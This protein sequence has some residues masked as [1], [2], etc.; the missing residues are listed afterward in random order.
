[1]AYQNANLALVWPLKW[2]LSGYLP[3]QLTEGDRH[4]SYFSTLFYRPLRYFEGVCC[5]LVPGL[6]VHV[7]LS[8]CVSGHVESRSQGE[9]VVGNVFT[10]L[11][12]LTM[13]A[14][15][16]TTQFC[17]TIPIQMGPRLPELV[18]VF[19]HNPQ[20]ATHIKKSFSSVLNHS[21]GI[22]SLVYKDSTS[23][24]LAFRATSSSHSQVGLLPLFSLQ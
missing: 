23:M 18:V 2:R 9:E 8:I 12:R 5:F 10:V 22:L 15:V 24:G 16:S 7:C 4:G 13:T 1:M 19:R 20:Q 6:L 14:R 3:Q 17:R 21:F 11:R